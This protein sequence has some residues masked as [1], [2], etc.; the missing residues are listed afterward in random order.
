MAWWVGEELAGKVVWG[1]EELERVARMLETRAAGLAGG[2]VDGGPGLGSMNSLREALGRAATGGPL[3]MEGGGT[4][5][6]T[7]WAIQRAA[8]LNLRAQVRAAG[9][10]E[11]AARWSDDRPLS[12]D[13]EELVA[14]MRA[15]Y[16][17]W[18]VRDPIEWTRAMEGD[19]G[20]AEQKRPL[21]VM[22]LLEAHLHHCGFCREPP[23]P[24]EGARCLGVR[25][26][27]YAFALLDLFA[28]GCDLRLLAHGDEREELPAAWTRPTTSPSELMPPRR[29]RTA[30]ADEVRRFREELGILQPVAMGGAQG[31]RVFSRLF[32]VRKE[33]AEYE[34][35]GEEEE[36]GGS[37]VEMA[38]KTKVRA[39][40]NA[41]PVLNKGLA[42][43]GFQYP[44]L[45]HTLADLAPG[46]WL[47]AID[48]SDFYCSIPLRPECR[49]LCSVA[50][51]VGAEGFRVMEYGALPFGVSEAPALACLV[52][53]EIGRACEG[54][55]FFIDDAVGVA[56]SEVGAARRLA[57]TL[58]WVGRVGLFVKPHKVSFPARQVRALGWVI[59]TTN[60]VDVSLPSD[61]WS[62]IGAELERLGRQLAGEA[63][64]D[65][66]L[67]RTV[68]GR[69]D[70]VAQV[71]RPDLKG[72]PRAW[73]RVVR[74]G[75]GSEWL[76]E[77]RE[78]LEL[79]RA[80]VRGGPVR[81]SWQWRELQRE[82][83]HLFTD[84]SDTG[85]GGWVRWQGQAR[86]MWSVAWENGEEGAAASAL[87]EAWGLEE[88][89]RQVMGWRRRVEGE[90]VEVVYVH[91][92]ATAALCAWDNG[93]STS[94][95]LA[96]LV[97]RVR[98]MTHGSGAEGGGGG[99]SFVPHFI[100]RE[101]NG[102]AD[103]LSRPEEVGESA[104][105]PGVMRSQAGG[106]RRGQRRGGRTVWST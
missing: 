17:R 89:V 7:A 20:A 10:G 93:S 4:V 70:H 27:C 53:G 6:T 62:T 86:A 72:T 83:I 25:R 68:A 78:R 54:Q 59:D 11:A 97:R 61:K 14:A 33:V 63:P 71:L 12:D 96:A 8:S 66:D 91:A 30:V 57:T 28:G 47:Y 44:D 101:L 60:G 102:I 50:L 82:P 45:A 77:A 58:R 39:C 48:I 64:S 5:R 15:S 26:S 84:A 19:G 49:Y 1:P 56:G 55:S 103:A 40:L 69:V 35:A 13:P 88:A 46:S 34:W 24:T 94:A 106:V 3:G 67:A 16:R 32:A 99:L 104:E 74:D 23:L 90:G 43:A 9:E 29:D 18:V 75:L 41:R 31:R 92:D 2:D 73:L 52:S 85:F 105:V 79:W 87:R 21:R 36:E 76:P 37:W 98:G 42:H 100:P 22:G 95:A 80:V 81:R 65:V 38:R 51:P